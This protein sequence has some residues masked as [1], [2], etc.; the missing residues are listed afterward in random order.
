MQL[1]DLRK[2]PGI[3]RDPLATQRY[4]RSDGQL[5]AIDPEH[6]EFNPRSRGPD[7]AAGRQFGRYAGQARD[8]SW[9]RTA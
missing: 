4:A 8:H 2:L 3:C 6:R 9:T 5:P 1:H 7:D